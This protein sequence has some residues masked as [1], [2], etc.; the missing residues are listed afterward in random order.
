[1]PQAPLTPS[2]GSPEAAPPAIEL[3]DLPAGDPRWAAALPVLAQL[4]P[5]LDAAALA[6]VLSDPAAGPA[7]LG[8]FDGDRCLGVA[9]WRIHALTLCGRQLY[10]DDLVTD[11][12]ARSQGVGARMLARLVELARVHGCTRIEL[13]S[14]VTRYDAHRFYLREGFRIA[15][16]HFAMDL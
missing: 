7:F 9:G 1:M 14:N 13:D 11:E 2:A 4:R 10:V 8:A 16:H 6:A 15:S 3:I 5:H 12:S